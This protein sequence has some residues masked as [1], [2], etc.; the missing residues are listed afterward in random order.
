MRLK[1]VA[2]PHNPRV[3]G[4]V[5]REHELIPTVVDLV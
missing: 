2:D 3:S 1:D 5:P 4:E